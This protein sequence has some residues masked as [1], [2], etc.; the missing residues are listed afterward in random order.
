[1]A[2]LT[3]IA[4]HWTA[5]VYTPNATDKQH[6]HFLID[7]DGKVIKGTHKPQDNE[8]CTDGNYAAHL[9]GGNTGTIGVAI[10]GM[11]SSSYPIKRVQLE[12]CCKLIAEL[13]KQYSIPIKN[14]TIFTHS[15]FGERNPH[16]TSNGKIDIDKLPCIALYTRKECGDW[17]RN[18]INWYRTK[19]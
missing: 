12:A 2:S 10:C 15:E 17:L 13:S 1:M 7:G 14:T 11:Y 19:L 8:N 5:G 16:T 18:K 4:I 3:K 6:Y 9:G